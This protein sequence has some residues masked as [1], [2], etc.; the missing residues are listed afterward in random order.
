MR[1]S[2]I[3][4]AYNVEKTIE[5]TM[6]SVLNQTYDDFEYIIVDGNSKDNTNK[7][8]ERTIHEFNEKKITVKYRS[9][10]DKGISDAFNK[11]I[12]QAEGEIIAIINAGD[13]LLEDAL[14]QVND[15]MM[16]DVD[17]LYGNIKWYE[18]NSKKIYIKK[19]KENISNLMYSMDIMHPASFVKKEVYDEVGLF[20]IS[21]SYAM[22]QQ[23]LVRMQKFGAKFM[24]VNLEFAE[25][26]AGGISDRNV[27]KVLTETSRIPM[28]YDA[29]MGKILYFKYFKY[30]KNKLS[31]L[32][33]GLFK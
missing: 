30:A 14:K 22:D 32:Y 25:M 5:K 10:Q 31:H 27:W 1:F 17:V 12:L 26:E 9:E 16:E 8:I 18:K 33:R 4:I 3:T 29:S 11:G 6:M 13:C 23:I 15:L 2:V 7:I 20:D 19:S 21:Y 28:E 24:Y